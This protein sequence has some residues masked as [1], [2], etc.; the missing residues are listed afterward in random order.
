MEDSRD[1]N[2]LDTAIREAEEEI[3]I[4][5]QKIEIV[6]ALPPFI[7]GWFQTIAV[8]PVIGLLHVDIDQL[9]IHANHEVECAFWVPLTHFISGDNHTTLR[10]S[11]RTQRISVE[12]FHYDEPATGHC[13][14]IWGLTASICTTVSSLA[15]GE[16]PHFPYTHR[17]IWKMDQHSIYFKELAPLAHMHGHMHAERTCVQ[18]SKL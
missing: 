9:Q 12:S 7:S 10:G 13:H 6:C 18:N 11:W 16:L 15:L 5:R 4:D 3:G 17:V 2:S 14:D 8:T 1:K